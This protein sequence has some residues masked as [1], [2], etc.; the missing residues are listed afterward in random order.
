MVGREPLREA[1][2][3]LREHTRPVD[4][5]HRERL[6][7]ATEP[8]A[9]SCR[10]CST[11]SSPGHRR[12]RAGPRCA[13]GA[14]ADRA[15]AHA[16]ARRRR[17]A[18]RLALLTAA[19]GARAREVNRHAH[20]FCALEALRDSLHRRG[21][22]FVRRSNRWPVTVRT[23][24]RWLGDGTPAVSRGGSL[25][26]DRRPRSGHQACGIPPLEDSRELGSLIGRRR[27][28]P[29]RRARRRPDLQ[30]RSDHPAMGRTSRLP[31]TARGSASDTDRPRERSRRLRNRRPRDNFHG[32]IPP[33]PKQPSATCVVAAS[34]DRR[35]LRG[36][37]SGGAANRRSR[38]VDHDGDRDRVGRVRHSKRHHERA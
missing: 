2:R 10:C 31:L 23:S 1:I 18:D 8:C 11:R 26:R 30:G 32:L 20:T 29:W 15:Q 27:C 12:R 4:E 7:A 33:E 28:R 34:P 35:L 17:D 3:R 9:G 21:A 13:Q 16:R 36:G 22:V 19:G 14:Q 38:Q 25:S 5:G 24:A 37:H 6:L